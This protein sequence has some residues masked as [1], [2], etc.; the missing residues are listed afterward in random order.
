MSRQAAI[1]I[2]RI[3]NNCASTAIT[4]AAWVELMASMPDDTDQMEI[5][6]SSG[7]VLKFAIGPSGSEYEIPYYV[8]PG[9]PSGRIGFLMNKG[10]RLTVRAVDANATTGLLIINM[11]R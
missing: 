7:S 3:L 1:P 10:Q 5:F 8:I 9:G 2:K 4:T 11:L 6:N